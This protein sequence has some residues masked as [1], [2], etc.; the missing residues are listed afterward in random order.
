MAP[1]IYSTGMMEPSNETEDNCRLR[2]LQGRW[3]GVPLY[4][5]LAKLPGAFWLGA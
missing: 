3:L 4:A 2:L 5:A 1:F